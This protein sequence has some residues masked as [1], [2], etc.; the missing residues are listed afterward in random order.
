LIFASRGKLLRPSPSFLKKKIQTNFGNGSRQDHAI[1]L[2][3]PSWGG[4]VKLFVYNKLISE[5]RTKAFSSEK[6]LKYFAGQSII[7]TF[8]TEPSNQA[9]SKRQKSSKI[10]KNRRKSP[11]IVENRRKSPKLVDH[12]I[13]PWSFKRTGPV[14]SI[15]KICQCHCLQ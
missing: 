12:N 14:M 1:N 6:F 15:R 5:N 3:C 10:V 8:L 7:R 13:D 2:V 4:G 11:K 9:W